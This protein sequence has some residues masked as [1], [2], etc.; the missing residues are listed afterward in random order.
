MYAV[1]DASLPVSEACYMN[2]SY[3]E[4]LIN[5]RRLFPNVKEFVIYRNL[6][7][8]FKSDHLQFIERYRS[9]QIDR[10]IK[11]GVNLTPQSEK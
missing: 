11:A 5:F 6:S 2:C 9:S 7:R 4:A 10:L 8:T 3:V 1:C